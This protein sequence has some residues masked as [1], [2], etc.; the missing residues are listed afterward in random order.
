METALS[1]VRSG[2]ALFQIR[3]CE[4]ANN[5]TGFDKAELPRGPTP[6]LA[7]APRLALP[8]C[9]Q[10]KLE[11]RAVPGNAVTAPCPAT[12]DGVQGNPRLQRRKLLRRQ[13]GEHPAKPRQRESDHRIQPL[14]GISGCHDSSHVLFHLLSIARAGPVTPPHVRRHG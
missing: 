14:R 10:S 4:L 7:L 11:R 2:S 12:L 9:Q 1:T 13:L 5:R 8:P 3:C 6:G